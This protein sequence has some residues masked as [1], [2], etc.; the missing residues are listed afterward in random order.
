[1]SKKTKMTQAE[2]ARHRGVSR[3]T[4]TEYKQKGLLVM[5]DGL[6]D[7]A[8]SESKLTSHLDQTRGG[9][10][11]SAPAQAA[12]GNQFMD[13]KTRE[14]QA[15]ATREE[16]KALKEMGEA[17]DVSDLHINAFTIA[18]DT[19]ESLI[20]IPDR[21]A[22]L[23]AVESDP[24]RIHEMLSEEIRNTCNQVADKVEKQFAKQEPKG[25]GAAA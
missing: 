24:A 22:S 20:S 2:F 15:K 8:Q 13:A 17:A 3:A 9:K 5:N 19:V 4:V 10:R 25:E 11:I 18:R 21:I 1:M 23:L 12:P 6:V 14:M 7:V 16:I